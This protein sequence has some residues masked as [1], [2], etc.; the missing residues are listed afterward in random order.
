MM[1]NFAVGPVQAMPEILQIGGEQVPY[2]RTEEFSALMLDNEECMKKLTAAS[3]GSRA[4]FLT[5]SGTAGMEA[6]VINLFSEKD[7]LLV[8][9]GGS[10]GQRFVDICG[11][12]NIPCD[13]VCLE[14]GKTLRKE[15]LAPYDGKGYTGFLVNLHETSTGTLYPA[16]LISAFCRRNGL[17]LVVDA[18]SAFL[19]D[20]LNMDAMGA[21]VVIT[22]SQKALAC[23]PGISALVLS[24]RALDRGASHR[25]ACMYLNLQNALRDGERG[26]TPY[27]P[28]VGILRQLNARF[29]QIAAQG[30]VDAEIARIKAQAEDFR[31][32][33][34][35]LPFRQFSE[36]PSNAL[37]ALCPKQCSAK[38]IFK[39]L[40]EQYNIWICPNS[41]VLAE[42]LFRV[43]HIGA[44]TAEDNSTLVTTFIDMKKRGIL[45][46]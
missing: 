33:I 34:K 10:F 36:V 43:G 7:R 37:T 42:R 1:L 13:A 12:H 8:V 28:A 44:L 6:A 45:R 16:E 2:F 4:V 19:A 9:N 14:P 46:D 35:D 24:P 29:H 25:S 11:Y 27:T 38:E 17:L 18:I 30:G 22:S 5:A 23:S 3:E 15:D 31:R 20:P 40:K 41:G 32:K 26:Q 39:V 21:D